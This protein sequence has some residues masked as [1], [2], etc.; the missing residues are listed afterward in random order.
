VPASASTIQFWSGDGGDV[1]TPNGGAPG[2][3]V[4][5]NPH[6]VWGDVS[7]N[8]G[9]PAGTADWI[10]FTNSGSG[11]VFLPNVAS[12]TIGNQTALYTRTFSI[13]DAGTLNFWILADDTATVV[14]DGPDSSTVFTAFPGQVDP[15]SPG[16][17]PGFVGCTEGTMGVASFSGLTAGLYTLNIYHFQTNGDVSGVQFAGNYSAPIDIL[18][19]EP[20]S[21]L[22]LATG[23]AGAGVRRWHRKQA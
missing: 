11:G 8:A 22:L 12:R 9:L 1:V 6:A 19:P 10:S 20:A 14:L 3:A 23:L 13:G 15:C 21:M 2:A 18:V 7:D 4:A 16:Y 5:I 17:G